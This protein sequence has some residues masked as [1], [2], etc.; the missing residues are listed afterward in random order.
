LAII[1]E[2]SSSRQPLQYDQTAVKRTMRPSTSQRS[3]Q[4]HI[5]LI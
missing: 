3:V 2:K 1:F 5:P 4:N